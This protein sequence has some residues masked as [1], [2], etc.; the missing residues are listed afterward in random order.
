MMSFNNSLLI[1]D[2]YIKNT[3]IT[4]LKEKLKL[5]TLALYVFPWCKANTG[6]SMNNL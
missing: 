4:S 3:I 6:S 5:R 2:K 1:L